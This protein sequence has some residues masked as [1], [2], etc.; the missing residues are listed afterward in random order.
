M[1]TNNYQVKTGFSLILIIAF[2]FQTIGQ[3]SAVKGNDFTFPYVK[4]D[5]NSDYVYFE[6]GR[7]IPEQIGNNQSGEI[8]FSNQELIN[9]NS[10]TR[11]LQ[12][13]KLPSKKEKFIMEKAGIVLLDYI[14][15]KA[16]IS[17]LKVG[18]SYG[19]LRKL[20]VR[21][22]SKLTSDLKKDKFISTSQ[23]PEYVIDGSKRRL[24]LRVFENIDFSTSVLKI[25]SISGL[26]ISQTMEKLHALE[27]LIDENK[28]DAVAKSNYV[29]SIEIGHE[30]GKPENFTARTLHRSNTINTSYLG[31]KKYDG[32]G[33]TVMMQDDGDIGP[34]IDFNGRVDQSLANNTGSTGDHGDH[35]AGTFMGAGN[36]DPLGAGMAPGVFGYIAG[37][38]NSNYNFVPGLITNDNL[39]ITTKSYSNGCNAG[40]TSLTEALDNQV[41]AFDPLVHVFSAGNSNG[42][43]CGYGAGSQWGNVTGGHKIGKNVIAVASLTSVDNIAG[44]SSRGPAADGRIKPDIS[45]NGVGVYSS[46]ENYQYGVKSGT[47]MACPGVTGILSQLY[48]AYRDLNGNADPNSALMKAIVLNTAEDLGNPGPDFIYGWG[49]INASEAFKLIQN[50]QFMDS[51]IG[52]G[53]STSHIL[54]IPNNVARVKIMLYWKDPAAAVSANFD[55][56]NDLDLEVIDP[57]STVNLPLVLNSTPNASSLNFPA[58]PGVDNLNNME[59]VVIDAPIAGNYN[60]KVNGS[61]V[62]QGPQDYFVVYRYEYDEVELTYPIGGEPFSPGEN[63]II[64]WDAF[65]SSA[66]F[67]LEYS[68]DSGANWNTINSNISASLRYFTWN[69]PS[70]INT[71][72]A[73]VRISRGSTIDVSE[74]VFTIL[75]VPGGLSV[76][77][78]CSDSAQLTWNVVTGADAYIVKKLGAQYMDSVAFTTGNT[79]YVS[80]INAN[81]PD[82]WLSVQAVTLNPNGSKI[83]GY[84]RR[85]YAI[86]K[87]TGLF[88]CPSEAP[89]AAFSADTSAVCVGKPLI[90]KN[91]TVNGSNSYLW[92]I[93]PSTVAFVNGTSQSSEEPE[94]Q[95]LSDDSYTV[96][97]EAFNPGGNDTEEKTSYINPFFPSTLLNED[98]QAGTSLPNNWSIENGGGNQFWNFIQVAS[99]ADNAPTIS[100]TVIRFIDGIVNDESALISKPLD[101]SGFNNPLLIFDVACTYK[102]SVPIQIAGGLRIDISENCGTTFQNSGYYKKGDDLKTAPY[103]TNFWRPMDSSEWRKDTLDLSSYSGNVNIKFVNVSGL[104]GNNLYLDNIQVIEN[105][106][107]ALNDIKESQF[108]IFPNPTHGLFEIQAIHA[109]K[110]KSDIQIFGVNGKVVHQR[111]ISSFD[112]EIQVQFDM[113]GM[114]SGFYTVKITNDKGS[115]SHKVSYIRK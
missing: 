20:N 76:N 83:T 54:N 79:L 67:T 87:Q 66:P 112:P 69:V 23:F 34:H 70:G 72:Q 56:V 45:A 60:I 111:S 30:E 65:G 11:V 114:P 19:D 68:L 27:I 58:V 109:F 102:Q 41:V 37:N 9:N 82:V 32:T 64:R 38:L 47:S 10:L 59:Q 103:S 6:S 40:Y 95:F 25:K 91:E 35:V 51:T 108:K 62:P 36:I 78:S 5:R 13:S 104:F 101:I 77:S 48:H 113:I 3:T 39:V 14:P 73:L 43:N 16:F 7:I 110:G 21:G 33:V 31:G 75:G 80:G 52:N 57:N 97:L 22:M 53:D 26:E 88:N 106:A 71:N 44:S 94:V 50:Q 86:Q 90:L 42:S 17:F 18:T 98:F 105:T 81:D 89:I 46:I 2:T 84:G 107:V 4:M 93:T 85:A 28:I 99:G 1:I 74:A 61:M 55:L 15:N 115:S 92:T 12:F 96:K 100:S 8:P 63:Q 24:I 49:R 29:K